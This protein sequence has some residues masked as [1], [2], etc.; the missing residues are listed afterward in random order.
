MFCISATGHARPS[1]AP[2]RDNPSRQDGVFVWQR[3]T[4]PDEIA[5]HRSAWM[6]SRGGF[7]PRTKRSPGWKVRSPARGSARNIGAHGPR[8][9]VT[10]G[11]VLLPQ[12]QV[13][14]AQ[15]LSKLAPARHE[16]QLDSLGLLSQGWRPG[17]VSLRYVP[18]DS[19][20]ALREADRR[21]LARL[22]THECAMPFSVP[23]IEQFAF[24]VAA[25]PSLVGLLATGGSRGTRADQG[26][27][28]TISV[29]F[30]ALRELS[31]IEHKHCD[32]PIVVASTNR[33]ARRFS[34]FVNPYPIQALLAR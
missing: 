11:R 17:Y 20:R 23:D 10:R 21:T 29:Q 14:G 18:R 27:C 22:G 34:Q 31:A 3:A 16:R 24:K 33:A 28:P 7:R 2:R 8:A 4:P 19:L 32:G 30:P 9:S 5:V 15:R 12:G 26:V 6:S 13:R 25:A 1:G